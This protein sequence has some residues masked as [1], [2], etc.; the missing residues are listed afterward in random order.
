MIMNIYV[1]RNF[2][3]STYFHTVC[4]YYIE[5]LKK[6]FAVYLPS[7]FTTK[8]TIVRTKGE[9]FTKKTRQIS[10]FCLFLANFF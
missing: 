4:M 1:L 10:Y 6:M 2:K 5:L 7:V 3:T 9:V 8:T